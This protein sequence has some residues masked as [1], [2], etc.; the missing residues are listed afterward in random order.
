MIILNKNIG[1]SILAVFCLF[2]ALCSGCAVL[3]KLKSGNSSFEQKVADDDVDSVV[4]E[5]SGFDQKETEKTI[6]S[7]RGTGYL[8]EG[9]TV[10]V[11]ILDGNEELRIMDKVRKLEKVL[12][13]ER[14][15]IEEFE[16]NL[17]DVKTAKE[18]AEKE[19]IEGKNR[20]EEAV[21]NLTEEIN[22]LQAKLEESEERA[23]TAEE[24]LKPLKKELL[25]AQ[26]S[27]TKAQQELFN[28]KIKLIEEE[29]KQP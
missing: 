2:A 12:D 19:F 10:D 14:K 28:L 1:W 29:K 24:K 23:I 13:L 3:D 7:E 18:K 11:S 17:N 15:R 20:L 5:K 21:R 4:Q 9:A 26:I 25:K 6:S 22:V 16:K 8:K 27:E